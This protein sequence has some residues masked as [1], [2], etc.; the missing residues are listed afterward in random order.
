MNLADAMPNNEQLPCEPID[1][2]VK[3]N[4]IASF[5][6][7]A[8]SGYSSVKIAPTAPI[9]GFNTVES[10]WQDSESANLFYLFLSDN[11]S[12]GYFVQANVGT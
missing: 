7:S 1:L 11:G 4:L 2:L 3:S 5:V 12:L 10:V 9:L 6:L 8:K